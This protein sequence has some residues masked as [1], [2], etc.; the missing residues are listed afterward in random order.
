MTLPKSS[1]PFVAIGLAVCIGL[2]GCSVTSQR[3]HAM[4]AHKTVVVTGASSGFGR[5]VALELARPQ[6]NV[7]LV[8]R[9]RA[10]LDE[11]AREAGGTTLVVPADVGN[12]DDMERLTQATLERFGRIDVW[13]NNAGA[14]ALGRFEDIPL[15]DQL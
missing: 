7:V 15:E 3:N 9:D 6:A 11:L 5:G 4:L 10:P 13:I 8:A 2:A 12:P 1:L 14:G